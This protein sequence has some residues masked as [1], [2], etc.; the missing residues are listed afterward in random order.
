[1]PS[2]VRRFWARAKHQQP[3]LLSP[4]FTRH[5][6][7]CC[8][9]SPNSPLDVTHRSIHLLPLRQLLLDHR[10]FPLSPSF[11]RVV[12]CAHPPAWLSPSPS[13]VAIRARPIAACCI[14]QTLG[15]RRSCV[16]INQKRTN[17]AGTSED[18]S[19]VW[20]WKVE[21]A[22]YQYWHGRPLVSL[23]IS[24]FFMPAPI[25]KEWLTGSPALFQG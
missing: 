7:S 19:N 20:V 9:H 1:M 16:D 8:S 18:I 14:P 22:E 23:Y 25:L 21:F 11:H 5:S 17:L 2:P 3:V 12:L 4:C 13:L 15:N 6:L 24:F 10:Q